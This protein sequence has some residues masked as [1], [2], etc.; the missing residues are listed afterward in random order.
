MCNN[1]G[2]TSISLGPNENGVQHGPTPKAGVPHKAPESRS[3]VTGSVEGV[4]MAPTCQNC[5]GT[6]YT[7][8]FRLICLLFRHLETHVSKIIPKLMMD[9]ETKKAIYKTHHH[10]NKPVETHESSSSQMLPSCNGTSHH[11]IAPDLRFKPV[12]TSGD[13]CVLSCELIIVTSKIYLKKRSNVG[14]GNLP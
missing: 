14:I 5:H 11:H 8:K 6:S 4:R 10:Q 13:F 9:I 3:W 12:V 2:Y 7:P 1:S